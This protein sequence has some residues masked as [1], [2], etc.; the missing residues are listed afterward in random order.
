M[1]WG[2]GPYH[3]KVPQRTFM[4]GLYIVV[5]LPRVLQPAHIFTPPPPAPLVSHY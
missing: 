4:T 5:L 3:I 2:L 1:A